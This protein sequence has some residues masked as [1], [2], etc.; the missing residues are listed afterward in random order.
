[1]ALMVSVSGIRGIVGE[2]LAPPVIQNY[3]LA[4]IH[5]LGKARGRIVVGRDTRKSGEFIE[6]IIEGTIL[7]LGYDVI[8]VGIAPTPTILH[9][10]RKLQCNG[11]IAISA[12]H[13]P[14]KWN[15]LKFCD[16]HGL[17]LKEQTIRLIEKKV[18]KFG[19][20]WIKWKKYSNLGS[21]I[22]KKS[23]QMHINEVMKYIDCKKIREKRFKVAIDPGG[24]ACLTIDRTF[25][26]KLNCTVY[27][28]NENSF[29]DFPR[30][31][32]PTPHN[33]MDLCNLVKEKGADVG[34]AQDPDGD[35]LSL[36]SEKGVAIGEEYT[37]VLAG[38]AFLRKKRTDI[39][40]NL[41]TSMMVDDLA[42]RFG[43]RVE[44]TKIGEINVTTR[45]LEKSMLFGG[46][47]NG[48]VIVPEI[49]PCRDSIVGM[50]LILE[51]MANSKRGISWIVKDIPA[52]SMKKEQ[53]SFKEQNR[54]E[55]YERILKRTK[56][57][58]SNYE[59]DTLDGIKIYNKKEWLHMRLSNTEPIIRIIAE[60]SSEE[61]TNKLIQTG[62]SIINSS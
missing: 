57:N 45:L 31:P 43:V 5:V 42:S 27:G 46:E 15:A 28:I 9:T 13:N 60:T 58:F 18:N 17:F 12:S 49:N 14:S 50:A 41:S 20:D 26:E 51:L 6:K 1:M 33:L 7:A 29:L 25:L 35:R 47:G 61:K 22:Q 54:E 48:G 19:T 8:N 23:T 62:I 56:E 59:I 53:A 40:C 32:E 52:Y 55:L 3:V 34:F 16:G 4:F 39:V 37:L 2:D 36:V 24:G 44:R 10:V 11:G 30:G 21:Y 38:E